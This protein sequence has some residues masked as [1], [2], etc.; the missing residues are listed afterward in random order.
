MNSKKVISSLFCFK[1]QSDADKK[2]RQLHRKCVNNKNNDNDNENN[3]N[4]NLDFNLN[5]PLKTK[6]ACEN[7]I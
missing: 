6:P 1:T 2:K 4:N 7:V 3:N 5:F